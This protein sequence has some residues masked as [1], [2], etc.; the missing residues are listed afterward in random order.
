MASAFKNVEPRRIHKERAQPKTRQKFGLLEKKKDWLQ[1]AKD[2]HRKQ[3]RIAALKR[4]TEFRNPDEFYFKMNK[5]Q[6][7][8]RKAWGK[9][10]T[11]SIP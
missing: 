1:R 9:A 6:T 7:K 3:D 5:A 11:C 4:K 2:Y 8:V 10:A